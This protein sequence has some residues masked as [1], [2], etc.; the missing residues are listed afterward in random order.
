MK[1]LKL[2][3]PKELPIKIEKSIYCDFCGEA[4]KQVFTSSYDE[5]QDVSKCVMQICFDCVKQLFK[6]IPKSI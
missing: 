1:K 4:D 2:T 5:A 3:K 6:F